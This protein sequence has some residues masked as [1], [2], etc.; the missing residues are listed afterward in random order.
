MCDASAR[1][2]TGSSPSPP[3]LCW[4]CQSVWSTKSPTRW[5]TT[6]T[7]KISTHDIRRLYPRARALIDFGGG[8]R[9]GSF[10]CHG[11]R[12]YLPLGVPSGVTGSAGRSREE[13]VVRRFALLNAPVVVLL[14]SLGG[15][16]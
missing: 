1:R 6:N 14:A 2:R 11:K 10:P 15:L 4:A 12:F 16:V 7:A 13:G 5:D 8:D 9:I 3:R